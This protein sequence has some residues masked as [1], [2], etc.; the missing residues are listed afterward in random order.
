MTF[1]SSQAT[2]VIHDLI[3]L[4]FIK[5]IK[6]GGYKVV[7]PTDFV[8]KIVKENLGKEDIL[9]NSNKKYAFTDSTAVSIWTDGYYWTDF[10]R[11]F[12]PIHIAVLKKDIKYWND[13][14]VKN[15][16]EYVFEGENKTLFGLTFILHP[17]TKITVENKDGNLV[18]P[19][20]NIIEFC[21]K[22]IYLYRPALEYLDKKYSLNILD[23]YEQVT[24]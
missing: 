20:K 17:K 13:F 4:D 12:K 22:N 19:L 7:Q 8:K 11:G 2:K 14:F 16:A 24:S 3:K 10:T 6:R 1:P 21:Q 15:D 23:N 18:I 5:R 9:K